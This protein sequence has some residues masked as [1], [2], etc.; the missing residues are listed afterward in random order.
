MLE[1]RYDKATKGTPAVKAFVAEAKAKQP[2]VTP[3]ILVGQIGNGLILSY[4]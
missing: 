1:R 2:D 3:G 4:R